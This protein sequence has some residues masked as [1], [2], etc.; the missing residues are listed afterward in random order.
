MSERV[1]VA[2][3]DIKRRKLWRNCVFDSEE[4][5]EIPLELVLRRRLET[6]R[7]IDNDT[8]DALMAESQLAKGKEQ[9][10][11]LLSYR[12][13]SEN[14]LKQRMR[15]NGLSGTTPRSVVNDL[16]R[17]GLVDDEDFAKR[18]VIDLIHRKPAGEFLI[19][20]ELQKKGV[21]QDIIDKV[22]TD[23]FKEF[24]TLE[25]ARTCMRQWLSRHPRTAEHE[26]RNKV[27]LYLYQRG[28]SKAVIDEIVGE[29][30]AF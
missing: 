18:F 2:I 7:K 23:I 6:G 3:K 20:A 9:S 14:E 13:R 29:E 12:S 26:K 16:K 24:D 10:L 5:V 8:F 27:G 30:S 22:I 11:R 17:L 19:K 25:L 21:D 15:Q 28:F 4:S 1:I